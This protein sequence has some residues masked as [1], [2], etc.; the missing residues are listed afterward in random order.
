MSKVF[1]GP[2]NL[3]VLSKDAW[4]DQRF[5]ITGSD[6]A[7]GVYPAVPGTGPGLVTGDEWT[8]SCEW[9]DNTSSGWQPSDMRHFAR[10]TVTEGFVIELGA[11][12]NYDE[13]RD[14]DY[15]DMV[16]ICVNQDPQLTPLHPVT[17][18]YDFS[19]A[20][21]VLD[22]NPR[23]RPEVRRPDEE[24]EDD[25]APPDKPKDDRPRSDQRQDEP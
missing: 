25:R 17:P 9:N 6:N 20:Q 23:R 12:D 2:W 24:V 4:F 5:V 16:V 15:N 19:V 22:R 3:T 18:F 21:D 8:V 13:F 10:Y 14:D 7:D 1:Y 11:D